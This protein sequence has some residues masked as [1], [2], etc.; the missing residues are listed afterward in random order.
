V[1]SR[2]FPRAARAIRPASAPRPTANSK[3]QVE[4]AVAAADTHGVEARFP[5]GFQ[6]RIVTAK[7]LYGAVMLW[8]AL[9]ECHG[10][11]AVGMAALRGAILNELIIIMKGSS[12]GWEYAS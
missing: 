4:I 12:H 7:V 11:V 6:H 2:P 10:N 9:M 3:S 1:L 5:H 8:N